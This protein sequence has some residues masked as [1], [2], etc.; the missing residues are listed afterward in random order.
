[1]WVLT[2]FFYSDD[3]D[4]PRHIHV[5]REGNTAKSWLDPVRYERSTGFNRKEIL[6]LEH[7]VAEN[8]E[9][10]RRSWDDYFSV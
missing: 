4:E 5:E 6:A 3:R 7:L 2:L 9:K 8:Q 10:L 1:M